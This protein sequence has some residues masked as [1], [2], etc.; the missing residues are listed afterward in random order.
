MGAADVTQLLN[1]EA[2]SRSRA[3][4]TMPC[5]PSLGQ[6][7][8]GTK[9][10]GQSSRVWLLPLRSSHLHCAGRMWLLST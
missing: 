8:L 1:G 6:A 5:G 3:L 10:Q 9:D 7:Q 2:D 4:T